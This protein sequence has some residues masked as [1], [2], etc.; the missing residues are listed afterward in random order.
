MG[1]KRTLGYYVNKVLEPN[2]LG[3][4]EPRAPTDLCLLCNVEKATKTGSHLVPRFLTKDFFEHAKQAAAKTPNYKFKN[5]V[6]SGFYTM[7][8]PPLLLRK[9]KNAVNSTGKEDYI[10]CPSC[11]DRIGLIETEM[12]PFFREFRGASFEQKN[13]K[14][15]TAKDYEGNNILYVSSIHSQI[16]TLFVY[17]LFWRTSISSLVPNAMELEADDEEALR[18]YLNN[19]LGLIADIKTRTDTKAPIPFVIMA[20][21]SPKPE[22]KRR[23]YKI[24]S[25][26]E[27]ILEID[28]TCFL[29]GKKV[30]G[31]SKYINYGYTPCKIKLCND[32][33]WNDLR[34]NINQDIGKRMDELN[35]LARKLKF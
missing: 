24:F 21:P 19:N 22:S 15:I 9:T 1:K 8:S 17:S 23:I 35:I 28:T 5:A 4:L 33:T 2:P 7:L 26:D 14:E 29:L 18:N 11:E 3:S 27:S 16:I 30:R 12:A 31:A 34:E 6:L 25:K 32:E 10:L 20:S 13:A